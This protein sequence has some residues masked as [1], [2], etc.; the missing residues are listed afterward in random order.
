[1]LMVLSVIYFGVQVKHDAAYSLSADN[2]CTRSH[3]V[4]V[5]AE[6]PNTMLG[7][8]TPLPAWSEHFVPNVRNETANKEYYLSVPSIAKWTRVHFVPTFAWRD[9][10]IQT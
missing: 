1:M 7:V 4:T 6:T 10:A 5:G 2:N 9:Y 3:G 8:I